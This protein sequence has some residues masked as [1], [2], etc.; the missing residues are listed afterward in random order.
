MPLK[1]YFSLQFLTGKV[2]ERGL[3]WCLREA[4][5]RASYSNL[6]RLGRSL[7]WQL[8]WIFPVLSLVRYLVKNPQRR[9]FCVWD[10]RYCPYSVGDFLVFLE[11]ALVLRLEHQLDLVDHCYIVDPANPNPRTETFP[12]I[13]NQN[14]QFPLSEMVSLSMINPHVG[15][16]FVFD[17]ED[18]FNRFAI[19][20]NNQYIVWPPVR[21]RIWGLRYGN[22]YNLFTIHA[23]LIANFYLKKGFI[24]Q[25][26][27]RPAVV[28]WA[29]NFLGE[30]VHPG[31]P[32]AVQLR[33]NETN[34]P[35]RN[36][37][38][39]TW[40]EFFRSCENRFP[41]KF[42]IVGTVPEV[43]GKMRELSNV[44]ISKDHG[45]TLEQDLSLIQCSSMVMGGPSGPMCMAIFNTKPY[46]IFN[47]RQ[48]S[49]IS[50][51]RDGNFI[52]SNR[53]QRLIWEPESTDRLV[54]EFADLFDSA[55]PT[56]VGDKCQ[57]LGTN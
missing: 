32:V 7:L 38:F 36:S 33:K 29:E 44:I 53:H 51:Q 46:L 30:H 11:A 31:L 17:S 21:E 2:R 43:D 25:L 20:T 45:T 5:T 28:S 27:V 18:C 37:D 10:L 49:T 48:V 12:H 26:S 24:P 40:R 56:I 8:I 39:S 35:S 19:A 14:Y 54:A 22:Y 4:I 34:D 13:T 42:I 52:F 16:V 50:P 23:D 1:R 15:S 55:F 6:Q 9:L 3:S 47:F 41:A 57:D